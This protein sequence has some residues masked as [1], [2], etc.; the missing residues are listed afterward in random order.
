MTVVLPVPVAVRFA[1]ASIQ[2][3]A[4]EHGIQILHIKG[5]SVDPSLLD[6]RSPAGSSVESIPRR[7]IDA[8]IWVNPRQIS[9]LL[10]L[11]V[12]EGWKVV[13]GF[14]AGSAFVRSPHA[15]TLHH[16]V[17]APVD[18]LA[19]GGNPRPRSTDCGAIA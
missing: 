18:P 16:H 9:A 12:L 14:A 4:D 1:H 17:L 2:A 10:D 6:V 8:D 11:M 5:P 13:A 3:L 15:T 7:S 19:S